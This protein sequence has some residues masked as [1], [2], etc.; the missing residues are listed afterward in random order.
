MTNEF[1]V[2]PPQLLRLFS[3]RAVGIG[4]FVGGPLAAGI[5]MGLNFRRL[6][7]SR[8][9]NVTFVIGL[10]LTA[11]L[12]WGVVSIP[13]EINERIPRDLL[14]AIYAPLAAYLAHLLQGDAIKQAIENGARKASGW[15]ITAWSLASLIVTLGVVI[16]FALATPPLGFH[17]EKQT[18]GPGKVYDVYYEGGVSNAEVKA[19]ADYLIHAEFFSGNNHRAVHLAKRD[20]EY[21]LSLPIQR[22]Y[23]DKSD[24][25]I[26]LKGVRTDMEGSILKGKLTL[27]L[28]DE[29][30]KKT[31]RKKL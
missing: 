6:G 13:A 3:T 22:Q 20:G 15:A 19:L 10:V 26:Y 11:L 1:V 12:I 17:G 31:Y 18:F 9:S 25:L 5:F 2:K 7:K 29:D 16:L 27:V 14:P 24:L 21:T 4:A 23:W 8:A 28:V 30:F